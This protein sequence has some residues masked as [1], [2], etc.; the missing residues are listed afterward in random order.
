MSRERVTITIRA[1]LLRQV[2][3]LVDGLTIRSRSQ[4]MEYLLSKFLSD[5]KLGNALILAGGPKKG[6]LI[7]KKP[8]FLLDLKGAPLLRKVMDG[9][10]EFNVSNFMVYV[11][12]FADEIEE[13]IKAEHVP[14]H[15]EFLHGKGAKGSIAP[16]LLAKNRLHGSFLLAYGDTLANIN[17]NDMLSFHKENNSIAT[18][19]LTTVSN[20]KDFGVAMLQ[21]NKITEFEQKP[22]KEAHSFLVNAG[23]F[24]FEPEVF[25]HIGRDCQ[26]I[27]KDLL[28]K[29]AEKGL[30]Y[31]YP[32]H[33]KYF[34][35]NS[36]QDLKKAR[37]ML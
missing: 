27:E 25:R 11:D 1:D 28:P 9:I 23:Y 24:I 2:D 6:L 18:V 10:N 5:F 13:A 16:L 37:A 31:G 8:K 35:I 33:G 7:N 12:S 30:L 19:A 26:N 32:F 14:Y 36:V 3:R 15:V 21:G 20:P 4:A 29:L 34:N 22:K 17:L